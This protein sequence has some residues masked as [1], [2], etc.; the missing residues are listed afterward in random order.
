MSQAMKRLLL[1]ALGAIILLAALLYGGDD[2]SLRYRI[3]KNREPF[4]SVTV[5][6]VYVIHEK[7]GKVEYQFA[8]SSDQPCVRSLV[9]HFGYSPCWYLQRHTQQE[10]DI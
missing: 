5:Q 10:I 6:P 9:P 2:L 8:P 3:P 1:R 4:G 7:N